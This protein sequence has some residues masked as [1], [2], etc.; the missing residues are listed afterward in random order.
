MRGAHSSRCEAWQAESHSLSGVC[1]SSSSQARVV[2]TWC[3]AALQMMAG[4][5]QG[6]AVVKVAQEDPFPVKQQQE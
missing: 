5:N 1:M 3:R 2:S 4:A 6:K